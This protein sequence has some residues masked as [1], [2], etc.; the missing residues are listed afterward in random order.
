MHTLLLLLLLLLL[1]APLMTTA[2]AAADQ[3]PYASLTVSLKAGLPSTVMIPVNA[4]GL[5][6]SDTLQ[7]AASYGGDEA[8]PVRL[9][10]LHG[11]QSSAIALSDAVLSGSL[12]FCFEGGTSADNVVVVARADRDVDVRLDIV[13]K[14]ILLQFGRENQLRVEV[15]AGHPV[16]F[17]VNPVTLTESTRHDRYLLK[18]VSDADGT[19]ASVCM[20]VA[21]YGNTCPLK[22]REDSIKAADMWFTGL[23]KGAMTIRSEEF[24]FSMPFYVSVV[25]LDSDDECHLKN[26]NFTTVP[27]RRKNVTVSIVTGDRYGQYVAP[28]GT[29]ILVSAAFIIFAC[30]VSPQKLIQMFLQQESGTSEEEIILMN[31]SR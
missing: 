25:V 10:V 13:F 31:S 28:I 20:M 17:L 8:P 15:S 29:S 26:A 24:S 16:T 6:S 23:K 3:A 30:V 2:A 9:T 27:D 18:V 11:N 7:L 5:N 19:S 12:L 14:K 21:A 22:D 1:S 4:T